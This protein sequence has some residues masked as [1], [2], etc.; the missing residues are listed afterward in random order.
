MAPLVLSVHA[1]Q[2]IRMIDHC[3]SCCNILE[4]TSL[5][6]KSLES[7]NIKEGFRGL[8]FERLPR[9]S[10]LIHYWQGAQNLGPPIS[11][12]YTSIS[13]TFKSP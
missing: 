1:M 2:Q 5:V 4:T 6:G 10:G 7:T 9:P 13:F 3:L 11:K 8:I 12:N